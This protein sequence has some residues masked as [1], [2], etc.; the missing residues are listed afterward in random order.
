MRVDRNRSRLDQ[1][2][3]GIPQ[4]E[5][6]VRRVPYGSMKVAKKVRLM[7]M[8]KWIWRQAN[9]GKPQKCRNLGEDGT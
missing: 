7:P 1:I 8:Q 5:A 4:S 6:T 2:L 3:D 9:L